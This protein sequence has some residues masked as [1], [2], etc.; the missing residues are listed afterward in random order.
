MA[1]ASRRLGA[2]VAASA[3]LLGACAAVVDLEPVA[4]V[5]GDAAERP[6]RDASPDVAPRDDAE[7]PPMDAGKD[8]AP[9][10]DASG[11]GVRDD[12]RLYCENRAN[13][14]LYELPNTSSPVV[15]TLRTSFSYFV[16]W[17]LGQPHAGGNSTWYYTLG[18][19]TAV[20]GWTPGVTLKTP[21]AFDADPSAYGLRRC[22]R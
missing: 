6:P 22:T 10:V 2:A 13:T 8:A 4:Y 9:L 5:E 17:G 21:D 18:D 3:V 14:P 16:C 20:H 1:S 11:C 7:A 15:N 12:G 19:D